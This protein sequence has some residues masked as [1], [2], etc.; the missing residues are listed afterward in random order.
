MVV[1][2]VALSVSQQVAKANPST[3]GQFTVLSLDALSANERAE[4]ASLPQSP[5]VPPFGVLSRNA[6]P[7]LSA[8]W[9]PPLDDGWRTRVPTGH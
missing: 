1:A 6:N 2:N 4:F 9:V 7:E 5:V 3:W 8:A